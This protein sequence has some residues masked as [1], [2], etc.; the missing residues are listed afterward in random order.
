MEWNKLFIHSCSVYVYFQL[1]LSSV[2][3]VLKSHLLLRASGEH[4]VCTLTNVLGMR[5][6]TIKADVGTLPTSR[7]NKP[8]PAA[9]WSVN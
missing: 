6:L 5:Q 4:Y 9:V 3:P 8:S 2:E 1:N 7:F